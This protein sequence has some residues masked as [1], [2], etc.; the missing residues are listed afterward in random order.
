MEFLNH[1]PFPALAFEGIDQHDQSF[2]VVVLRQT[3]SFASGQLEYA[4]DQAPLC[5]A[6][7]FF[8]EMNRSSVRQES[9]LCHFKLKC[10][11]IVNATAYAPGNRP[12]A[13]FNVRLQ[14]TRPCAP[15][16]LPDR[17]YG[18]NPMMPA[19]DAA[20][21]KWR[22]EVE[23]IK[24]ECSV[25]HLVDKTL[26]VTGPRRF[27]K[28]GY[29]AWQL[30]PAQKFVT[31]PLRYEY[32]FGGQCR[33]NVDDQAAQYIPKEHRLTAEQIAQH[34]ES[35]RPPAA[36]TTYEFNPVGRGYAESWYLEATRCC[37]IPAPQIEYPHAAIDAALFEQTAQGR[38][39]P[40]PVPTP[41]GFGIRAKVHPQRRRLLGSIDEDFIKSDAWLPKDFDFA[42]WNS[43]PPDQQTEYLAGDE[44]IVLTNLCDSAAPGAVIDA[45]GN[46]VLALAL[47]KHDCFALI[48][49]ESGGVFRQS[50]SI[51]TLL[52]EPENQTVTL[53]WRIV[54]LKK[55]EARIRACEARMR[56]FHSPGQVAG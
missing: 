31:L 10:D 43:A 53:V 7:E 20:M 40:A 23:R 34:P 52:I 46:T 24:T 2:H 21:A 54:M 1:T 11:I 18:L 13:K 19:S 47:L 22:N 30:T 33:I 6:D 25:I 5:E 48:H 15:R 16:P 17:P 45:R 38:V 4:D 35:D 14:L 44:T 50:L 32:A 3:L 27:E 55:D 49:M 37:S 8:D 12:T 29:G 51:D 26:T 41:A 28:P 39:D 36:H 42:I 56:T 9:D